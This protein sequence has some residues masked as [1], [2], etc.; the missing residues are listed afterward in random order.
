MPRTPNG[1]PVR[2][3]KFHLAFFD[4]DIEGKWTGVLSAGVARIAPTFH[5]RARQEPVCPGHC[6]NILRPAG[7]FV[8]SSKASYV[9]GTKLSEARAVSEERLSVVPCTRCSR[10]AR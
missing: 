9:Q 7:Y 10:L 3:D 8:P 5:E 2:Y 6:A 4:I 1:I